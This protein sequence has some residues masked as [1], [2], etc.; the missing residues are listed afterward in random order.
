MQVM[1]SKKFEYTNIVVVTGFLIWT[2]QH[3]NSNTTKVQGLL[4]LPRNKVGKDENI[5]FAVY[6]GQAERLLSMGRQAS[7][8]HEQIVTLDIAERGALLTLEGRLAS[9]GHRQGVYLLV[10]RIRYLD[11]GIDQG[12]QG[13]AS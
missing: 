11:D 13:V 8:D 4:Y 9:A 3:K 10:D 5:P 7:I 2:K 6:G 12:V 1:S